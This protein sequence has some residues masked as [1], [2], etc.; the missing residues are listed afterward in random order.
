MNVVETHELYMSRC[1]E[2]AKRGLGRTAPNPLVGSVIVNQNR[3]IGEGYH[4]QYGMPHA[5]VNAIR[6]VPDRAALK[7][8]ILYVNLEPCS[9]QG[10]TPPCADLIIKEG[11]PEVIIGN[12]DPN[13]LVA[14][15]GI[16]K[17][18]KAGVRVTTGILQEECAFVNRRFFTYHQ[19]KRPYIILKWAKTKDGLIDMVRPE[20]DTKP[21]WIS[22]EI[23]KML[24][25]KWR[26]EE[27]GIL[28]GTNTAFLDDPRL[29]VREWKGLSPARMVIDESL[30]LPERLHLFDNTQRTI[31][32]NALKN[33]RDGNIEYV[34]LDFGHNILYDIMEYLY[35]E[36]FQ[37]VIVEGGRM[38]L[39]K[40]LEACLWD[41][42]RVFIGN[43]M[44]FNGIPSPEIR[45]IKPQ[46]YRILD[47]VLLVYSNL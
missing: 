42:A 15:K 45:D 20:K 36:S 28:V 26:T 16:E 37:S 3:I 7:N 5:E 4:H 17:L 9:H 22:N 13:P 2:L 6:S 32:F 30:S 46:E 29:N 14:G 1:L 34:K 25:H 12:T 8:A 44:F 11:I 38:L 18:K 39:E 19:K 21:A 24:V 31:V 10:K 43:K 41:E 35:E 27:Q 47:D 23:S 33:S 40:L